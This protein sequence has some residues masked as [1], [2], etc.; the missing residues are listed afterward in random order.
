MYHLEIMPKAEVDL[1][2][3]DAAIGQRVLDKLRVL[4]ENCD[5]H[6][7]EALRGR[8]R[9]KFRLRVAGAYRVLYTFNRQTKTVVVHEVGHRSSVLA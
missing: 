6:R 7:H 3:L 5:Q 2:R 4:C 1:A 9:G 8:H